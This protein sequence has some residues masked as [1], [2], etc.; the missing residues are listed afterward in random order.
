MSAIVFAGPSL[1]GSDRALPSGLDLRPPARQ[2]D[3]YRACLE[4]PRLIG[5]ID[6]YF[7]G[8]PSVWHKEILYA[9]SRGIV[10]LGAA[11]MGALRAVEL[12]NHGMEGIGT[13]YQWYRDG[14]I[15]D[16]DEVAL[17]HGPAETGYIPLSEPMVNVRATCA[18]AC[19]QKILDPVEVERIAGAA[20][21][22]HFRDRTLTRV[23][24]LFSGTQQAEAYKACRV[25]LKQQD[26]LELL[27]IASQ[28]LQTPARATADRP[29]FVETELWLQAV[30]RWTDQNDV[31]RREDDAV[32]DELRLDPEQ[33]DAT[34]REALLRLLAAG[35]AR[36]AV[37]DRTAILA[38]FSDIRLRHGLAH[39]ADLDAWLVGNGFA[40]GEFDRAVVAEATLDACAKAADPRW[41]KRAMITVLR[42]RGAY[43]ELRARADRQRLAP[44]G[45]DIPPPVAV[46]WFFSKQL[47]RPVPEDLD[48]FARQLLLSKEELNELALRKYKEYLVS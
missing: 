35:D 23:L 15:E 47:G 46:A 31:R 27:A 34:R 13:V 42:L 8:V 40:A 41:L 7:E 20:K 43:R 4:E 24:S 17:L 18:A 11:S 22:I 48:G 1:H 14:V 38:A 39:R 9:R 33:F 16:D 30:S 26:A 3:V 25:N 21:A 45:T 2:G 36:P 12:A 29:R 19:R 5:I 28:I 37:P 32:L 6:G 10:V 44:V